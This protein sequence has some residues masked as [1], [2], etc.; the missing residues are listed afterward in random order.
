MSSEEDFLDVDK[1]IPG[2]NFV[3]LSFVSPEKVLERKDIYFFKEFLKSQPETREISDLEEKLDTFLDTNRSRLEN[4]FHELN[5]FQT[6]VR[7]L[8]VRGVYDSRKEAEVRAQVLQ[9]LDRRFN[10]YVAQVGYWLPWDP[11]PNE[12]E[13]QVYLEK[14][15][16]ELM[17]NYKENEVKRDMFYEEQKQMQ[18]NKAI[19]EGLEKKPEEETVV[20][21]ELSVE[22]IL[23]KFDTEEDHTARKESFQQQVSDA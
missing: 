15:L 21:N 20:S 5:N 12:V 1:P 13:E 22:D 10:V 14:E 4:Q 2:Q 9:R 18:K 17:K 19:S 8:K 6:T 16:N 23:T 7:G 3:C 11:N